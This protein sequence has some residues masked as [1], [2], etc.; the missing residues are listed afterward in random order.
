M[1][2]TIKIAII[3]GIIVILSFVGI[4][5]FNS[6]LNIKLNDNNLNIKVEFKGFTNARDFSTDEKNNKY[7]AYK[8]K[9]QYISNSGKSYFLLKD[10]NLDINSLEYFNEKLYYSS[11]TK[12]YSYDIKNKK[13]KE[14]INKLPNFGDY[15][16]SYIKIKDKHLYITVGSATNSGV[17]GLDN[18][19]IKETP[20]AYDMT[21]KSITLKGTNFGEEKTGAFVP[22][23]TKNIKGEIVNEHFPGNGSVLIFNLSSGK[24]KT[25]AWGIR[26]I[27][28]LDFNSKGK[29]IA[30]VGGMENRGLRPVKGDYD[31]I[32]E[33]D[34]NKWYGFPD[35][36]GGDPI[37]SFRFKGKNNNK[38]NFILDKHPTI[39][40]P[41]PIYIHDKVSAIDKICVDKNGILG[42]KNNIY[43]FD[44]KDYIIYALSS[45][46]KC[47]EKVEFKYKPT[48]KSVK[49]IQNKLGILDSKNGI[50]Y[51]LQKN[52]QNNDIS[53]KISIY[54]ILS[55]IV[56][57]ILILLKILINSFRKK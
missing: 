25:F 20:Y 22:Y 51:S 23:K 56:I 50:L 27:T 15:K 37:T 54:I 44:K 7:I 48:V 33:I 31:Y 13:Q 17:V 12:V 53:K 5:K 30:A 24:Y 28:G 35:Y 52:V 29:L 26:N 3:L 6:N 36:T 14:L 11:G 41:A 1:R 39:N 18:K 38:I 9:I 47:K 42:K 40:P 45:V 43:F 46:G 21:P 32:Y 10:N 57:A 49:F 34:K 8:N 19:W 2:K 55:A 4:K 16:D